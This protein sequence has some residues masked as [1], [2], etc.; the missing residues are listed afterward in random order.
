VFD[1]RLDRPHR[2]TRFRDLPTA[3]AELDLR[4]K[5]GAL[6]GLEPAQ[7]RRLRGAVKVA[8]NGAAYGGPSEFNATAEAHGA[9]GPDGKLPRQIHEEPG[10]LTDPVVGSLVVG[11]CE[12]LLTI[13]EALVQEAVPS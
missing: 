7:M 3:L 10:W 9:W 11:G 8:R 2:G 1:P 6:T 13:L 5:A 4:A 12:L